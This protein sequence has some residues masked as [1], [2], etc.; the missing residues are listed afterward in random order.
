MAFLIAGRLTPTNVA[1]H[2]TADRIGV[3]SH[4]MPAELAATR[5]R[6]GDI[7]LGRVDV[8]PNMRGPEP[9]LDALR[10]LENADV[11]VLNRA[12]PLL[13]AHDKAETARVLAGAGLPHPATAHVRAGE[14]PR[15]WFDPPYVVKPRFGSWG[16]D[17]RRCGSE[18]ELRELLDELRS[19]C[20]FREQGAL[21]QEYLPDTYADLRIVVAAGQ[22][23]GAIS[24]VAARGE[25]RTNVALGGHRVPADPPLDARILALD[26]ADATGADLVGVDL[27][28]TPSGWVVLELNGCVDFTAEYSLG[29]HD[30]F[31]E[32]VTNLVFPGIAQLEQLVRRAASDSRGSVPA[33]TFASQ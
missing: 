19:V 14:E 1:L 31:E 9:G 28:P 3:E 25:W 12:G 10:R 5:A 20:W 4:L 27:L 6:L 32:S 13:T 26:A 23:V 15:L 18:R 21:V 7:V 17:V 16:V 8:L 22:V 2:E 29:R 30:V 33:P 24:R 11:L